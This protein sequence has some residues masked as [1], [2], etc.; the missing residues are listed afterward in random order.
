MWTEPA[1]ETW[2]RVLGTVFTLSIAGV[3]ASL[4][5]LARVA[6]WHEWIFKVTFA[7]LGV[8][9]LLYSALPWI[10]DPPPG[11]V[12][13]LGVVMVVLAAFAVT[14]PVV[15]WLDRAAL[16][17]TAIAAATSGAVRFCP[18]C[19][20]GLTTEIG[21]ELSCSRCGRDFTVSPAAS[22]PEAKVNLT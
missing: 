4:L 1:S 17:A 14:I 16:T 6:P 2:A 18:Y 10:D 21:P 3:A 19:G 12:R 9:A 13:A 22:Q 7:L 20:G 11:F 8:G 5:I 15:H